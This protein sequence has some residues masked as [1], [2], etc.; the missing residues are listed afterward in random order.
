[1]R[2]CCFGVGSRVVVPRPFGD[3]ATDLGDQIG[4]REPAVGVGSTVAVV[5]DSWLSRLD[6][7]SH[8]RRPQPSIRDGDRLRGGPE[9]L[10]RRGASRSRRR[11]GKPYVIGIWAVSGCIGASVAVTHVLPA[12][13]SGEVSRV[14]A[15]ASGAADAAQCVR[16]TGSVASSS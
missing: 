4:D 13:E 6:R 16:A 10:P 7:L 14:R 12:S 15:G 5:F 8:R 1:L 9:P 2:L 3:G 11:S